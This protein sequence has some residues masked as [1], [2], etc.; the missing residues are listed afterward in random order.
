M[1]LREQAPQERPRERLLSNG[2][3]ALSTAEL[4]AIILQTGNRKHSVVAFSQRLLKKY[5]LE[6][7]YQASARELTKYEGIGLAKAAKLKAVFELGRRAGN[8]KQEKEKRITCAEDVRERANEMQLLRQE[9][10]R[11]YQ[12]N[13][14]NE[15]I[16]EET[17]A[18]G[19]VNSAIIHPREV[20]A[21]AIKEHAHAIIVVHN[22]PSGDPEPSE[23]DRVVT[24]QLNETGKIVGIELLD[25]V[26]IGKKQYYS[27]REE[28][29]L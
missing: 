9:E 20:Y 17:I 16:A 15:V 21:S 28:E 6:R 10:C 1:K 29:E 14:K 19:T 25:H 11:V 4:L 7:L 22:H 24:R 3:K 2:A 12:L 13:T 26:I 5:P 27:F 23:E 8:V 18:K